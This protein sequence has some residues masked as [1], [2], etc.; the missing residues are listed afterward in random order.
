MS[1]S[2]DDE[3]SHYS[4]FMSESDLATLKG[5]LH[6]KSQSLVNVEDKQNNAEKC[7]RRA[8]RQEA[9]MCAVVPQDIGV[10]RFLEML[11]DT[12]K[13]HLEAAAASSRLSHAIGEKAEILKAIMHVIG[14]Y[15]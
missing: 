8:D 2:A 7:K 4:A 9:V 3:L 6:D 15:N 14:E 1:L 13:I 10:T 12:K 5:L 11:E